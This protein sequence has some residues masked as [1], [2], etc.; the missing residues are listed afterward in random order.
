MNTIGFKEAYQNKR[1]FKKHITID[2]NERDKTI[3]SER[4]D[5]SDPNDYVID[6]SKYNRF[7][8]VITARIIEAMI[9][10]SQYLI[11]SNNKYID[12]L[13]GGNEETAILTEGNY[14]AAGLASEI[15]TKLENSTSITTV[16]VL[17][18][19]TTK[20]TTIKASNPTDFILLFETGT[21]ADCSPSYI[22]GY[23]KKDIDIT[24]SGFESQF[25]YHLNNTRY[26][27][28]QIDEI[29]DLGNTLS[30]KNN[31]GKQILKRIP[32]DVDFGKEKFY[33]SNDGEKN[34]NYFSPIELSKLTIK[35]FNDDGKI[36]DSNRIDNYLIIELVMLQDEAPDNLGFHPKD[37]IIKD[38][39]LKVNSLVDSDKMIS[40]EIN[41]IEINDDLNK[42]QTN[43]EDIT[44][45]EKFSEIDNLEL[46]NS[47]STP[48]NEIQDN[49][50][51]QHTTIEQEDTTI[52]QEDN[53]VDKIQDNTVKPVKIMNDNN[54]IN[55]TLDKT[56]IF[57]LI[58]NNKL[59][60]I[61]VS[62]ILLFIILIRAR[63]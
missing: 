60:I 40:N 53:T 30:I 37:N 33:L 16:T 63:N 26:V 11:N 18:S 45:I 27:D 10:N 47:K 20:K 12:F 17:L 15:K 55:I 59:I 48:L 41:T 2:S 8:N 39:E 35:I 58:Q 29:P 25:A 36:Y 5:Y 44:S 7:K 38:V 23:E 46:K 9:P 42:K 3:N 49:N 62:I 32:V 51:E 28:I 57:E 4:K 14:T 54:L 21:N 22:L 31:T 56:K 13:V 52:E 6:I 1:I 61:T 50:V 24:S 19:T 43:I 34:Y